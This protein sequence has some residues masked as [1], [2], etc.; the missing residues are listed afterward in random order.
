MTST[1]RKSERDSQSKHSDETG[2]SNPGQDP[3][4]ISAKQG[5]K[6]VSKKIESSKVQSLIKWNVEVLSRMLKQIVASRQMETGGKTVDSQAPYLPNDEHSQPLQE[7]VEVVTLPKFAKKKCKN[8]DSVCLDPKV[9]QQLFTFVSYI[10]SLYRGNPFHNFEHASHV[11][12]SVVKLMSRIVAPSE[13]EMTA[14]ELAQQDRDRDLLLHDH[15]YGIVSVGLL[16]KV[17]YHDDDCQ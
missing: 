9:S 13:H 7:V 4:A 14:D 11:T 5:A 15:T 2:A 1:D 3:T 16:A 10:A 6:G 17:L 12:M 8:P